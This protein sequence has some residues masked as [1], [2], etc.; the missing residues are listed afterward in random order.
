MTREEFDRKV[1]EENAQFFD[2][3]Q[4]IVRL[5]PEQIKERGF[6]S[7]GEALHAA[8]SLAVI[9]R[10]SLLNEFRREMKGD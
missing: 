10:Q 3:C 5:S 4:K 8:A 1:H 9:V 6:E 7:V 2:I